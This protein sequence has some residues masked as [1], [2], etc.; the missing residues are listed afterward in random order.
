[1]DFFKLLERDVQGEVVH[2]F[3]HALVALDAAL[4]AVVGAKPFQIRDIALVVVG[5]LDVP[6][7][8][9]LLEELEDDSAFGPMV[10]KVCVDILD[11]VQALI[12]LLGQAVG[13]LF[14]EDARESVLEDVGTVA[15][16]LVRALTPGEDYS[17]SS[18]R[19]LSLY[20]GS[21]GTSKFGRGSARHLAVTGARPRT[22]KNRT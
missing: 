9:L 17:V 18:H 5:V 7:E 15:E 10:V 22:I 14:L 16:G 12:E 19:F 11:G 2:D 13:L 21:S 8:G 3:Q 1:V 4:D 20:I 6:P